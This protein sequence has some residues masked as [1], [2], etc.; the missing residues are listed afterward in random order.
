MSDIEYQ[1][2][3]KKLQLNYRF[4]EINGKNLPSKHKNRLKRNQ[5]I[6]QTKLSKNHGSSQSE[7]VCR[8]LCIELLSLCALSL[9]QCDIRISSKIGQKYQNTRDN[10]AIT[11][12]RS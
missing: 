4:L 1:L 8:T 3:M 10:A 7:Y 5:L 2:R 11:C 9:A 6:N 12:Q